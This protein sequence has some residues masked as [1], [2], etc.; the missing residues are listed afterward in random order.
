[1][2]RAA[3]VATLLAVAC[4]SAATAYAADEG[5]FERTLQVGAPASV[6]I[7]AGSGDITVTRG[8]A[9]VVVVRGRITANGEWRGGSDAEAAIR[10]VE[11]QPPIVQQGSVITIGKIED[12]AIARKVSVSYEVAVPEATD[13]TA[14][15]GSG[16]VVARGIGR[17]A[18]L[19]SGSGAINASDIDG[20]LS[21]STGSGDVTVD[22]VKGQARVKSGSGSVKATGAG[23]PVSAETGSGDVRVETTGPGEVS[24]SS[25]S[26]DLS[27]S[28]VRG[29][30]RARSGSGDV[31]VE[32]T[33]AGAWEVHSASGDVV[34]TLPAT[35]AFTLDARSTSGRIDTR[36]PVTVQGDLPKGTLRGDVRGGGPIVSVNTSSGDI[37]IR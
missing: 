24:A 8:A 1:M 18:N 17:D 19:T 34:L 35:A 10:Q 33:P 15:S 13:V 27:I 26:G 25:G 20:A 21:A 6:S 4:V 22:R 14:R 37:T 5:R 16:D 31:T 32:G 23:G 9:G 29:A 30:L 12:E 28:G 36:A 3:R 11:Q 7:T 2:P